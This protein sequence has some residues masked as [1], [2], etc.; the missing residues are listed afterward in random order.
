[1][2]IKATIT[3]LLSFI[4]TIEEA[5]SGYNGIYEKQLGKILTK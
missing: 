1:M 4:T 2:K 3:I 5:Q